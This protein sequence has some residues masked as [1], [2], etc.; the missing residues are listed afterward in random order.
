M[1]TKE[2]G[3]TQ[4]GPCHGGGGLTLDL[5]QKMRDATW[6]KNLVSL[7]SRDFFFFFW[8]GRAHG[9]LVGNQ[10]VEPVPL[11][12]EVQSPNHWTAREV[13]DFQF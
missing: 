12:M 7:I 9:I 10:W 1:G 11:A 4:A 5:I 8:R 3:E 6:G 2:R 13:P